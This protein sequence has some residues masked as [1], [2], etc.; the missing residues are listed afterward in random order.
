MFWYLGSLRIL[1][2]SYNKII[3]TGDPQILSNWLILIIGKLLGKKV[4]LW[5]HGWYGKEKG[6]K[7][8]IKNTD[9]LNNLIEG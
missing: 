3:I 9:P 1:F 6:I 2:K 7:K 4:Y 5:T 8:I